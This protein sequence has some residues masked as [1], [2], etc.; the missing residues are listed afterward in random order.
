MIRIPASVVLLDIE[1]TVAPISFVVGVLFPHARER[2]RSFLQTH[3]DSEQVKAARKQ[4][5]AD[6]SDPSL[7]DDAEKLIAEANRL[8]DAD[9]KAT[10]LK[11]LQGLI[12]DES[13]RAGR[14]QSQLFPDVM[15]TLQKWKSAG[16][17]LAIYSSGSVAAQK[18][19]F[20][21]TADGDATGLLSDYFDTTSGPKRAAQSYRTISSSLGIA[22][23]QF[24]FLTDILEEALAAREAGMNAAILLRPGNA[25][26]S[27]PTDLPTAHSLTEF[28]LD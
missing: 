27:K 21:Y 2:L 17:R 3:W 13:Y 11:M 7:A 8:M 1:G 23:E 16:K 25:P 15:P 4:M 12:W 20:K 22:P 10:G 26:L 19:F 28:T 9:A 6:A 5:A 24:L 14:L 18:V